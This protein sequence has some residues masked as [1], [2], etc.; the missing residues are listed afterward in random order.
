MAGFRR[1]VF[2]DV[3]KDLGRFV[4]WPVNYAVS[5]GDYGLYNGRKCEFDWRGNV[6]VLGIDTVSS[7]SQFLMDEIYSTGSGTD[8]SFSGETGRNVATAK[9]KFR[10]GQNSAA[11]GHRMS[12]M[13]ANTRALRN[14]L[15]AAIENASI[16]WDFNLV[17]VTDIF[18]AEAFSTLISANRNASVD[19]SADNLAPGEAFNIADVTA[20]VKASGQRSMA[21]TGIAEGGA[22]PYFQIRK[23]RRTKPVRYSFERYG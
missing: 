12:Y 21:Y 4:N 23:L 5:L 20:G 15:V 13:R 8:I 16:V 1:R 14:D 10:R 19:I 11:Q 18:E 9:V 2:R 6:S 7:E 17:V 3:K 22:R